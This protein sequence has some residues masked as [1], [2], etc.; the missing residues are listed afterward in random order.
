MLHYIINVDEGWRRLMKVD[1]GWWRSMKVDTVLSCKVLVGLV[2]SIKL[3]VLNIRLYVERCRKGEIKVCYLLKSLILS[4]NKNVEVT[5]STYW[6]RMVRSIQ[7]IRVLIG[8]VVFLLVL[9]DTGPAD[10][11]WE[12]WGNNSE[13][14]KYLK[15][16]F[17]VDL[18]FLA[19]FSLF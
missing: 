4:N 19:Q 9:T 12:K 5:V 13:Y 11:E 7:N 18:A 10:Y 6:Y 15:S 2:N 3:S 1:E 14:E 16:N 8:P 17:P